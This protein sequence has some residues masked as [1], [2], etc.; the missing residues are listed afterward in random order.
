MQRRASGGLV[1]DGSNGA[2]EASAAVGSEANAHLVEVIGERSPIVGDARAGGLAHIG[3]RKPV[4][5]CL[6]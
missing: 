5:N 4:P 2:T 6:I 3:G 1:E